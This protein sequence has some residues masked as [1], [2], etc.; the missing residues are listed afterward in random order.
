[1]DFGTA[2]WIWA[3]LSV[4]LLAAFAWVLWKES[5]D[6]PMAE[7]AWLAALPLAGYATHGML[8]TGQVTALSIVCMVIG[9]LILVR[10]G[11][12]LHD[13]LGAALV[14]VGLVKP[15]LG[16]PLV[17]VAM[18]APRRWRPALFIAG[19]YA[20]ITIAAAA[21]QPDDL[22]ALVAG[23]LGQS[24]DVNL[25]ASYGNVQWA[26]A[27]FGMQFAFLPVAL[28]IVALSGYWVY[29]HRSRDPWQLLGAMAIVARLLTYHRS[30]DDLLLVLPIVALARLAARR[31]GR[32]GL[33]AGGLAV[34]LWLGTLAPRFLLANASAALAALNLALPALWIVALAC[35]CLTAERERATVIRERVRMVRARLVAT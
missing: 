6:R 12:L 23:W 10:G 4:V 15:T 16:V 20:A 25:R 26:L 32:L 22:L 9:T 8:V 2:R 33:V 35:L 17:W 11:E 29:R 19:G 24:D 27:H 7:R 14:I 28:A 13:V 1:V 30:F 5:E 21:F 31:D 3:A 18:L 34:A